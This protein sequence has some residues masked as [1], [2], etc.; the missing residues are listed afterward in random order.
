MAKKK[1]STSKLLMWIGGV[2]GVIIALGLTLRFTG[3]I[4]NS[5]TGKEVETA[6]AK[7]KTIT[8]LVSASG[9]VQP[10]IEVIIR[11]DVSGEIIELAVKEGD[12]VREGDLLVRIKP[13]IYQAQID[14]LN[15]ALLTQKARLEQTKASLI[16]AEAAHQRDKKLYD[17]DLIS[18]MDYIQSKS[19]WE[20][21][22]ASLK[23]A[24]YQIQSAEAQLRQ[25][26]EELEQ[27]VIRAPQDGTVTGLG[28]EEGE[29]VLGNA[30]MA[31]TEMM[32]VSLL[33]R[34]EVLVEVNENDIVN[35]DFADTTRIEVDA[36]PERRFNGVVTE[37]ANSAQVTGSGTN[38][39]VTNYQVKVR[40]ITPH[41]LDSS[42]EKLVR[43]E[44]SEDP[45]EMFVPKF[46]PG[47][48]ATVDIE[49]QTA[50]NVVSVP[51]QAVT[52]RDF[53]KDEKA[54][55]AES[56]SAEIMLAS[57]QDHSDLTIQEEDIRKV[58]FVVEDGQA[59]RKEVETGISDN[60][61]IQILSGVNA[62]EE[63]VIGSYRTLSNLLKDG[64]NVIVNN[65]VATFN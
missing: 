59:I 64:D 17:K 14:N 21:Q 62:G 30:Q 3:V 52:V 47:M 28:V 37:I 49:T 25:A 18:E 29:R 27:T 2:L 53:A 7:L 44:A 50:T 46:R 55:K 61:H 1:S 41:N 48:S 58:V 45:E 39:Q 16:R 13:D 65:K 19:E 38:E 42:P 60:T 20:S 35:V 34:M 32:R 8:Q 31:G 56:D 15:A 43:N 51:I 40:I 10:E 12:F 4:G 36:Y 54:Q 63:I 57:S 5:E 11:P 6:T 9:K 24:E 33:D 22:K 23:A 26:Q